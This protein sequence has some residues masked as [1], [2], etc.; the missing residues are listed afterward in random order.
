MAGA[1]FGQSPGQSPGQ[2]KPG[3]SAPAF[4]IA[5]VHVIPKSD[6]PYLRPGSF[7]TKPRVEI[8]GGNM[9][10]LIRL[11][12][13]Y[14]TNKILG[15]PNWLEQ[16]RYEIYAKAPDDSTVDDRKLMLQSL[17]AE[18][19][20]LEVHKAS[21]PYPT[22]AL[23]AGKKPSLKE[24]DGTGESGC[25]VEAATGNRPPEGGA[26]LM[27]SINGTVTTINLG[28]GNLIHYMCRNIT[29]ADFVGGLRGMF[30]A[31]GQ[32]NNRPVKDETGL[33]GKWNFDLRWSIGINGQV[34]GERLTVADAIEKQLGLKLDQREVD[35]P[36]LM[37]DRANREP[38]PNPPGIEAVQPA[39]L[40]TEFEVADFKLADH[41]AGSGRSN[42]Q[43]GGRYVAEHMSLGFLLQRAF[44]TNSSNELVG[45]PEWANTEF[46]NI[47]AK[48]AVPDQPTMNEALPALL[49]SL[50][51]ERL[52]LAYHKEERP[53][54]TFNLVA[55]KPKLKKADP[56]SRVSCHGEQPP[57]G[58][59][60]SQMLIC[61][62]TTMEQLAQRLKGTGP[63]LNVPIFDATGIEGSFDFSLIYTFSAP[64]Q[65]TPRPGSSAD[66]G[67]PV[68]AASDP[69]GV[70][71]MVEALEKQLGLKLVSNKRTM[72]VTVIDHIER[73]PTEN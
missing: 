4:E 33:N 45:V 49:R 62:N 31:A 24:A 27:T 55:V 29:M 44:N 14:D 34:N 48:A 42:A 13:G 28:A 36:V 47:T 71:T 37:V 22:Y 5:D 73:V 17:L 46:V 26:Q 60:G 58:S 11:A 16:E 41:N 50:L 1:L 63:G 70:I 6:N 61:Q 66:N 64:M 23:V 19:F 10:D 69:T 32:L 25:K 12:Y 9:V 20:K 18:R 54:S 43:P 30:G 56:D 68:P 52:K 2:S 15:G 7:L 3:P 65:F 38:G 67:S 51:V 40:P 8:R 21:K 39:P 72:P 53:V 57:P 35:T 59:V